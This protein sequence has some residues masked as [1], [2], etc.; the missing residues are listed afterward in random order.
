M[1]RSTI[2]RLFFLSLIGLGMVLNQ[3][4]KATPFHGVSFQVFYN[5]LSPYGDW[6]MDPTYGYVWVPFVEQ[7]FHPYGTNGYW[8]MTNFGNTWVSNYQWGWAPFHY[9]RWF[10]DDYLGWAWVPGYEWGPAWV[11]WRTGG[12]YYGWAPLGPGLQV[13]VSFYIPSNYWV[14]VPQ[15]RFRSRN[16]FRYCAPSYY[17]SHIY[18]RTTVIRNTYVY[19][20]N[21]YYSGP[22][23]RDIERSTRT[24]VPVYQVSDSAKPGRTVVQN[25][26]ISVYR[27]EVR[28]VKEQRESP[29]PSRVFTAEEYKEKSIMG[30]RSASTSP[31]G[32]QEQSS[33]GSNGG[34]V[35]Q[36]RGIQRNTQENSNVGQYETTGPSR[37]SQNSGRSNSYEQPQPR[38]QS[39][40]QQAPNAVTRSRNAAPTIANGNS[41]SSQASQSQKPDV[42]RS[43]EN[44]K[45]QAESTRQ[46]VNQRSQEVIK[47]QPTPSRQSA[48]AVN[49]RQETKPAGSSDEKSNSGSRPASSSRG[50]G[51]GG[52]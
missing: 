11:N 27:P 39:R 47:R 48:P 37:T 7:G 1:K 51:R 42:S 16:F 46:Q 13:N 33:R 30:N 35:T 29:R 36:D 34:K 8:E 17:V 18:Q 6:V 41:R 40:P 50:G 3:E 32:I 44:S 21:T 4:S 22:S 28:E 45:R 12:G 19:N 25:N 52:N 49:S 23:R 5:E 26:R 20:N 2:Y 43:I 10:W 14:F 15:R 24:V 9:G 31:R 38:T